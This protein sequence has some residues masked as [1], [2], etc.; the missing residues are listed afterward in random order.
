MTPKNGT[1]PAGGTNV[2]FN[3]T[4]DQIFPS[5]LNESHVVGD[6]CD[7]AGSH[8]L[9]PSTEWNI[10]R[11]SF[12]AN[13][14][15]RFE[16][17]T[18]LALPIRSVLVR[19]GESILR[20]RAGMRAHFH[21]NKH[22]P[23]RFSTAIMPHVVIADAVVK[24]G[25]Q[26][27]DAKNFAHDERINRWQYGRTVE[28]GSY[29][30]SPAVFSL[31]KYSPYDPTNNTMPL[32]INF[33]ALGFPA[34]S[35]KFDASTRQWIAGLS[36]LTTPELRWLSASE[37]TSLS[38]SIGA[39]IA[40]PN[41]TV[42][43]MFGCVTDAR[44]KMSRIIGDHTQYIADADLD[45]GGGDIIDV[46]ATNLGWLDDNITLPW[47]HVELQPGFVQYLNPYSKS[48]L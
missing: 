24:F 13:I 1:W 32:V 40:V 25:E 17:D 34:T 45:K 43:Q 9:C 19:G 47:R 12:V 5:I 21:I 28:A 35:V 39:L 16:T 8:P 33:T 18:Y 4:L 46:T 10:I 7:V 29:V 15:D 3:G 31:C 44:W 48:A 37:Q 42:P 23:N 27:D 11:D 20:L 26:W 36:N 2:Y 41:S 22:Q 6:M 14:P 30:Y 38:S